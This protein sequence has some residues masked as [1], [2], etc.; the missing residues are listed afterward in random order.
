M[1]PKQLCITPASLV[2]SSMVTSAVVAVRQAL[3]KVASICSRPSGIPLV[4]ALE[5]LSQSVGGKWKK[6]LAL[7]KRRFLVKV[8]QQSLHLDEGSVYRV[9]LLSLFSEAQHS[10]LSADDYIIRISQSKP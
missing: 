4:Q 1:R 8:V 9:S 2:D 10:M 3:N 6:Q 5:M 7:I